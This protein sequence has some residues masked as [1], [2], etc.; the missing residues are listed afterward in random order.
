M[1]IS[2]DLAKNERNIRERGLSFDTVAE[3]DF[4]NALVYVDS[5]RD[6]GE[7]RYVALGKLQDRVHVLCFAETADGIRIISLRKGNA[8]EVKRHA[9]ATATFV[10]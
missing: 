6:Y 2:Y 3:F 7:T 9:K 4:E 5:R 10:D 1:R 8:R